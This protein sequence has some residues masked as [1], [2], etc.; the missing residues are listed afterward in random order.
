MIIFYSIIGILGAFIVLFGV[1][2]YIRQGP[3]LGDLKDDPHFKN[4]TPEDS[5]A[6][7]IEWEEALKAEIVGPRR[8]M[9]KVFGNSLRRGEKNFIK[10]VFNVKC[11]ICESANVNG[12]ILVVYYKWNPAPLV[13]FA[14]LLCIC[15]VHRTQIRFFETDVY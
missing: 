8:A 12:K 13:G 4:F 2:N 1:Y 11:P 9:Y 7:E 10:N 15:N 6:T 3:Y 5:Y 14:G